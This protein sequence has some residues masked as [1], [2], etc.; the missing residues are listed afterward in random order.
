MNYVKFYVDFLL[1]DIEAS[2]SHISVTTIVPCRVIVLDFTFG[3]CSFKTI[4]KRTYL[5]NKVYLINNYK[6][7]NRKQKNNTRTVI[8]R[9]KKY[10][11]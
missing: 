7:V 9:V 8:A 11:N 5:W 2:S 6:H 4:L 10:Y 1:R 3:A